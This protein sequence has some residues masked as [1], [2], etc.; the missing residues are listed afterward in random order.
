MNS[1][2]RRM[3]HLSALIAFEA[4]ARHN[5]FTLA[6]EELGV[7][8]PAVS[9]QVRSLEE[10]LGVQLFRRLHRGLEITNE[11]CRL[12][13]AVSVAFEHIANTTN[14]L[15]PLSESTT[16]YVGVPYA[17]ASYW[18]LPR[19]HRWRRLHPEIGL[20]LITTDE[21]FGEISRDVDVGIAF[22]S[23]T[24]EG[25]TSTLLAQAETYPVCSPAYLKRRPALSAPEDLLNET[26]ISIDDGRVDRMDWGGWFAEYQVHGYSGNC[27]IRLNNLPL[28]LQA[29]CEGHGVALGW[30]MLT[31]DLVLNSVLVR[32]IDTSLKASFSYYLVVRN[33]VK[34]RIV[35]QFARWITKQ[36][37][38]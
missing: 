29:A 17:V 14:D 36:C 26:L 7:T 38:L 5:N 19:L 18:L 23:G 33:G 21:G 11:G 24:W 3:P 31:D 2:S 8:Q 22:G 37:Q 20:S 4:A 15:C 6:A 16:I 30:N 34:S 32:P 28:V 1:M 35:Q 9:Q 12:L 13:R 10:K 27:S 25:F